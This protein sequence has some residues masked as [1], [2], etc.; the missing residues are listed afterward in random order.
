VKKVARQGK[1][2]EATKITIIN[3]EKKAVPLE[4]KGREKG[5][6]PRSEWEKK[7]TKF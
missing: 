2:R 1:R 6:A 7:K 5:E 4:S 3:L